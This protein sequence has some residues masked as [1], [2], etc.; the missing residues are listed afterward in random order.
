MSIGLL[1]Y[2]KIRKDCLQQRHIA[3]VS[4]LKSWRLEDEP[5]EASD[6]SEEEGRGPSGATSCED[7]AD[8]PPEHKKNSK[9]VRRSDRVRKKPSKLDDYV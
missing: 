5:D 6:T 8:P 9:E 1:N 7:D 4:Q 3:H 2:K